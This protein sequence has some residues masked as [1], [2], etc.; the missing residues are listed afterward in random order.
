MRKKMKRYFVTG[1]LIVV[2]LYITGYVLLLLVGFMDGLLDILPEPI[3][4]YTYLPYRIPGLG[5]LI[6]LS[7]IFIVGLL[8]ANFLGQKLVD[9]GERILARIPFLNMVYRATKQFL[10]AIFAKDHEGFSRVVMI[11]Y[12]RKG[13]YSLAFVTGRS[14]G[15]A[16]ETGRERCGGEVINIFLPTTPNPTSGFYLVVP[17]K[18]TMPIEMNVE[19]AFKVIMSAGMVVPP[20]KTLAEKEEEKSLPASGD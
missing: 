10:E 4:P 8:A 11:E 15:E 18:D 6:T 19:D 20:K 2:P 5:V 9:I 13:I 1:L 14:R 3:R 7:A 17:E 12:P 16:G